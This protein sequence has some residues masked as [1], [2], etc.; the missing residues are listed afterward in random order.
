MYFESKA[1]K[2][3]MHKGKPFDQSSTG[4]EGK[5][6]IIDVEELVDFVCSEFAQGVHVWGVA[7]H[8]ISV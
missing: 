8:T 5:G 3:A 7:P 4:E 1:C 2:V 6:T